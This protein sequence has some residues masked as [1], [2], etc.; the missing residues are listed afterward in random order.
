[1]CT[2]LLLLLRRLQIG[3]QIKGRLELSQKLQSGAWSNR[4]RGSCL[5]RWQFLHETVKEAGIPW[6]NLLERKVA[7]ISIK[8]SFCLAFIYTK[9]HVYIYVCVYMCIHFHVYVTA[10]DLC[11]LVMHMYGVRICICIYTCL[12][13]SSM[14]V[15]M[16]MQSHCMNIYKKFIHTKV[17][18]HVRIEDQT[19]KNIEEDG[20]NIYLW[21]MSIWSHQMKEFWSRW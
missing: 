1:M 9:K 7:I 10:R 17:Q 11:N 2:G 18:M 14:H 4:Q 19:Q 16:I 8:F 15:F 13:M 21:W 6:S 12:W 5:L 3:A 20:H